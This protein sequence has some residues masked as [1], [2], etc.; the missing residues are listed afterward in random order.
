MKPAPSARLRQVVE[1]EPLFETQ[2]SRSAVEDAPASLRPSTVFAGIG[3]VS[4]ALVT[5]ALPFDVLGLLLSAEHAR[6]ALS[7]ERLLVLVADTHALHNGAP[8][9]LLDQRADEYVELLSA[10][11]RSCGFAH[12]RIARA[13]HWQQD[14]AYRRVLSNVEQRLP[15]ATH[16][17]VLRETADIAYVERKYGAVVKVG[18]ALQRSRLGAHRDE[19]L[20]DDTFRRWLGGG[21]YFVYAKAGR[22]LDDRRQKVS[23]YVVSDASRRICLDPQEDVASKLARAQAEVSR[24]TYRGVCNHLK[25]VTRSYS[26]LVRPLS[27]SVPERAQAVIDHLLS[28]AELGPSA[29]GASSA[30]GSCAPPALPDVTSECGA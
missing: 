9:E 3:L 10:I 22:A 11:A 27:G 26:K 8:A 13:S 7:A 28:G 20:F 15:G 21:S 24:S 1:Q 23:P 25:A 18:W 12:M 19:R 17:Y 6:R 2:P 5:H 16:P 14:D 4:G 30:R 29:C